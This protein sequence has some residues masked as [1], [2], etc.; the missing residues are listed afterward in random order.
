MKP[1]TLHVILAYIFI[2]IIS[3]NKTTKQVLFSSVNYLVDSSVNSL[4]N[5]L[6]HYLVNNSVNSLF[7]SSIDKPI[8]QIIVYLIV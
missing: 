6:V 4:V 2:I 7:N 5:D 1:C 8:V 3:T